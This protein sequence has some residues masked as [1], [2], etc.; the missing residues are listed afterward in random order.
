MPDVRPRVDIAAGERK[1][2]LVHLYY[3]DTFFADGW[4][5]VTLRLGEDDE[6]KFVSN[7]PCGPVDVPG[8]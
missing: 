1:D 8:T 2:G 7:V 3:E 6:Y 5:C 4:K